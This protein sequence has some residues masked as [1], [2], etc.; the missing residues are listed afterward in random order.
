MTTRETLM[1]ATGTDQSLLPDELLTNIRVTEPLGVISVRGTVSRLNPYVPAGDSK[2]RW[3][4]GTLQGDE[5]GIEFKCAPGTAPRSVGDQVI[6]SGTLDTKTRFN[7]SGLDVLISGNVTGAWRPENQPEYINLESARGRLY[8]HDFI[9]QHGIEAIRVITTQTAYNDL[10]SAINR[11]VSN[12]TLPHTICKFH[13][14]AS[15]LEAAQTAAT[16]SGTKGIAFVRGGKGDQSIQLWN[17]PRFVAD[18]LA[19]GIPFY[20]AI[21]HT[22]PFYLVEK[23]CDQ[24]FN[25][26]ND[27]GNAMGST[28]LQLWHEYRLRQ[29]GEQQGQEIATLNT[30]IEA[31]QQHSRHASKKLKKWVMI[32]A[33][34]NAGL[35]GAI[36]WSNLDS[37]QTLIQST[38]G[39]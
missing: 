8:L 26:P 16:E 20:T 32:L 3:I 27:L 35:L 9:R 19:L 21:G 6:I 14:T 34:M 5:A 7:S 38:F 36:T 31:V 29:T 13:K 37:I 30:T 28:L 11:Q 12:V 1:R 18:L 22:D 4:Y 25:N 15:L 10:I 39:P 33:L 2:P 24:P 23:H 17:D